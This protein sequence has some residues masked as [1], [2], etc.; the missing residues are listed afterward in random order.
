MRVVA[1]GDVR[2]GNHSGRIF[3]GSDIR[4]GSG[5]NELQ[6]RTDIIG[7]RRV[8][9]RRRAVNRRLYTFAVN[10]IPLIIDGCPNRLSIELKSSADRRRMVAKYNARQLTG[11]DVLGYRFK[12]LAR[13]FA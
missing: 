4:A 11:Y 10:A 12:G 6:R 3:S 7:S 8:A 9:G 5:R 13:E 1:N 2:G